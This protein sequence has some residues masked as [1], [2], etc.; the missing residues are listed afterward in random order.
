MKRT[1][2]LIV[3]AFII[4]IAVVPGH[5]YAVGIEGAIGYWMH[6]PSGD[7]Q[8]DTTIP[9][10]VIDLKDDLGYGDESRI[11]GRVKIDMPILPN[12]YLMATPMEFEGTGSQSFDFGGSTFTGTY[13]SKLTLNHYD[14]ALYYGLPFIETATMDK[15]NIEV[16]L[17]AR[18][19][20]IKAE[21]NQ[22]TPTVISESESFTGVVPMLYAGV[23]IRPIDLIAIEGEIRG[24]AYNDNQYID[25]ILR[26]KVKP[27]GPLFIAGGYRGEQLKVEEGDFKVDI[28]VSGPFVEA[29]FEF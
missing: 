24:I 8:S 19:V 17:N 21:I 27:L 1:A 18:I 28:N 20:D 16:G 25:Y 6:T 23:Q 29:G 5:S 10:S 2:L 26:A 15:F 12:I 4:T 13:T 14:I 7:L 11:M 22:T 9:I 3:F